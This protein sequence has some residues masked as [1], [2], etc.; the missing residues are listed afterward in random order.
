MLMIEPPSA[1]RNRVLG[2]EEDHDRRPR[3]RETGA[4]YEGE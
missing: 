3:E 1:H 4:T 2:D